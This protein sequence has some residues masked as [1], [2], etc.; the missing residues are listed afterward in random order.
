MFHYSAGK[1][2]LL[3]L[4]PLILLGQVQK[5]ELIRLP[6]DELKKLYFDNEI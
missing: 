6:Y 4:F 3:F 2:L 5:K 1:A